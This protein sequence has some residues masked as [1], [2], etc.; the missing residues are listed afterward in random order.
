MQQLRATFIQG[1]DVRHWALRRPCSLSQELSTG[2]IMKACKYER[3]CKE[4]LEHLDRRVCVRMRESETAFFFF[5]YRVSFVWC[6]EGSFRSTGTALSFFIVTRLVSQNLCCL[7]IALH[8]IK[9]KKHHKPSS[10]PQ[11]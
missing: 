9:V 4:L 11:S 8:E 10:Y 6:T 2:Q 1:Q 7:Y 3:V 5:L